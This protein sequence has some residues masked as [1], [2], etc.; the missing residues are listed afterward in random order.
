MPG[1]VAL[2][3]PPTNNVRVERVTRF[4]VREAIDQH[5]ERVRR[6][7]LML[8]GNP[9]DA[10]DL[11]QETFLVMARDAHRFEGRSSRILSNASTSWGGVVRI[12]WS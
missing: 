3:R 6:A 8:T 7:A 10:D 2:E 1:T 4:D 12:L 9:W 5:F 11:T